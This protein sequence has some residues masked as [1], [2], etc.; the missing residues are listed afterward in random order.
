[1]ADVLTIEQRRK[2]MAAITGKNTMPE[3]IVRKL[4]HAMGLRYRLYDR[5]LPGKPD[6]VFQR[7]RKV[8]FVHGCF[9][10]RHSCKYGQP[11][12][13]TRT[14]FWMK[15]FSDNVKRDKNVQ[16]QI[17][18]M[19][20]QVMVVWECQTRTSAIHVLERKIARFFDLR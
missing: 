10:H 9:W 20:W 8:I 18:N 12:P 1:M 16:S 4:I 14:D 17:K 19:G 5:K 6:L 3:I 13:K 2:C 15:K 7:H 11:I